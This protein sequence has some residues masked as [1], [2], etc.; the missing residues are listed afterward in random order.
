MTTLGKK[1]TC[2]ACVS[3]LNVALALWHHNFPSAIGWGVVI[4]GAVTII[5][6]NLEQKK[7]KI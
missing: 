7:R 6:N 5:D 4:L 1:W 3:A 2:T